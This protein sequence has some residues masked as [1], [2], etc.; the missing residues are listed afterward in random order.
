MNIINVTE[1]IYQF[2]TLLLLLLLLLLYTYTTALHF[3]AVSNLVQPGD[4]LT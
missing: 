1:P 3:I 2:V 4:C